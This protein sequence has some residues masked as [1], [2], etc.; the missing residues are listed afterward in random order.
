VLWAGA[1]TI[2]FRGG[3]PFLV[4]GAPGGRK[5]MSAVVQTV[6]NAVDYGDAPQTATSRPRIHDEGEKLQVDSRIP[7]DV[8]ADL[9]T[10][11]HEIEV[12]VEDVL[13]TNFARPGAIQI[14]GSE[15]RGGVEGTKIGIAL[16]F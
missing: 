8:R 5:I 11:G 9:A 3:E 12:K 16:G 14:D 15:L 4:C 7:D 2:V 13:S 6:V 1:P 10:M